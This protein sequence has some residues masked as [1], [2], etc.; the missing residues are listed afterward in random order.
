MESK[1]KITVVAKGF[2][3]AGTNPLNELGDVVMELSDGRIIFHSPEKS[4]HLN[5]VPEQK[6]PFIDWS[7]DHQS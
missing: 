6:I 3:P 2:L 1:S 5:K 7:H 4:Y